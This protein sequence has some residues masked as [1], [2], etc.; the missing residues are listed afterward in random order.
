M[1]AYGLLVIGSGPA[2]VN[3]AKAYVAA[4]GPGPVGIVTADQD[5]PYQR[6]PLSKRVLAGDTEPVGTQI[7]KDPLPAS[8]ELILDTAVS[9]VDLDARTVTA[10]GE[11]LTYERLVI[12]TGARPRQLPVADADAEV[13]H[14]R[15]LDDARRLWTSAGHARSA[16]VIGSGFIGCEAAASLARRGLATTLVTPADGP[17]RKRLGNHV[18]DQITSWLTD[19]GVEVRTGVEVLGIRAPR[20]VHL[21]DGTTLAPDLI[22]AAVGIEAAAGFLEGTGL[23]LHEGRVVA[24][25]HLSAAPGVWAAGDSAR[26]VNATAGRALSVEHWGDALAMGKLAGANAAAPDGAQRAWSDVPGFWSTIGEHTIKYA[27]WGD[28]H[29]TEQ[30]VERTG[31]FTVWYGDAADI[32]VGVLTY[33][34]DDDDERGEA[35]VAAGETVASAIRGDRAP[36][37]DADAEE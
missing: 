14:L 18:A 13:H 7:G 10:G 16:V 1:S 19:A 3:A 25:E 21:S 34:A 37:E 24:D 5:P 15:S 11:Q 12:A 23:Q 26:A 33:N 35:L 31:G 22:L 9:A 8:V 36:S 32:L 29:E 30:V 6:P 27:A 17:Q 20:T 28:G 4:G 2:G